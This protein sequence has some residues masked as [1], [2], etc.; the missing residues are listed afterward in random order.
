MGTRQSTGRRLD[1][2]DAEGL[3]T[4][5]QKLDD[6][7][8]VEFVDAKMEFIDRVQQVRYRLCTAECR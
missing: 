7:G 8:V 2:Q 1:A 3:A 4:E 6:E 5:L